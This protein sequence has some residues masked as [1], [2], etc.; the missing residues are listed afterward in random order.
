MSEKAVFY[1]LLSY[2]NGLVISYQSIKLKS[3]IRPK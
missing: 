1:Y 2:K 3:V